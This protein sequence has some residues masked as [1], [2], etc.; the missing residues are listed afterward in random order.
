LNK[1]L[2]QVEDAKIDIGDLK[3]NGQL[4]SLHFGKYYTSLQITYSCDELRNPEVYDELFRCLSEIQFVDSLHLV[5]SFSLDFLE[6]TRATKSYKT[7]KD[8][9]EILRGSALVEKQH[10]EEENTSGKD[11]TTTGTTSTI[12]PSV[13]TFKFFE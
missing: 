11:S 1:V 8:I 2:A 3:P 5:N 6:P 13:Q 9:R 10:N 12:F 7:V 4:S